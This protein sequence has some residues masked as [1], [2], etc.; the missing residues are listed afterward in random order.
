MTEITPHEITVA[1]YTAEALEADA[2]DIFLAVVAYP[3][4]A[5]W[6]SG[7]RVI[8]IT[9]DGARFSARVED[10]MP[11]TRDYAEAWLVLD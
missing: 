10:V 5:T 4:C 9:S 2:P 11:E 7:D 1:E 6:A 8:V 3:Q